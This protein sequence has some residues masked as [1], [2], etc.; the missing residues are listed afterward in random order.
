MIARC[1]VTTLYQAHTGGPAGPSPSGRAARWLDRT[2]H[3]VDE[4]PQAF[5]RAAVVSLAST[6]VLAMAVAALIRPHGSPPGTQRQM[7]AGALAGFCLSA[8]L[9][10]ASH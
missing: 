6:S 8:V 7:I 9:L 4:G 1:G 2:L 3:I 5:Y 10:L